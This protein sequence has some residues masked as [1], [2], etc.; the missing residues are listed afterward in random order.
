VEH[1]AL[2]YD[3]GGIVGRLKRL[4]KQRGPLATVRFVAT[5]VFRHESHVVYEASLDR[6][7]PA[8]RWNDGEQLLQV[9]SENVDS[10]ITPQL[11]KFLGG[12]QAFECLEGVRNGD[13][14][15]V[16]SIG[17]EYVHR[18]YIMFNTR[19]SKVIGD[20]AKAPL[21]GYCLTAPGA[22]GRG[23]Y[24]R[25]LQA[26]LNY[27]RENGYNRA[28][29]ETRP[30]NVASRKGIEAAGFTLAWNAEVWIVLNSL[31]IQC[32]RNSNGRRWRALFV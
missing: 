22:R 26:E 4:W 3:M 24:R 16:V 18:G 11:K 13:R 21:I 10:A 17:S 8:L 23:I 32:L 6:P 2:R 1:F 28:L 12:D 31:V 25:A 7:S 27:L 29:I 20:G 5:R 9:G 14:L 15:F 19:Q 30:A